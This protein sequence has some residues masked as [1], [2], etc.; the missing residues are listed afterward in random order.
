MRFTQRIAIRFATC[1]NDVYRR[2]IK[3]IEYR[4][5]INVFDVK[6]MYRITVEGLKNLNEVLKVFRRTTRKK[7]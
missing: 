6:N 2:D 3:N 5:S 4:T 7:K 1:E